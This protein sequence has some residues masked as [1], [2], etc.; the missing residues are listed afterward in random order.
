MKKIGG[1]SL[2]NIMNNV[3]FSVIVDY[4]SYII[5]FLIVVI[6]Y[7][8]AKR[9]TKRLV[10]LQTIQLLSYLLNSL[11]ILIVLLFVILSN[12]TLNDLHIHFMKIILQC[13]AVF[14]VML[15]IFKVFVGGKYRKQ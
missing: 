9:I 2:D 14:G 15:L 11:F 10:S 3:S 8:I 7:Q 1:F 13:L 12:D 5:V 4:M 6:G